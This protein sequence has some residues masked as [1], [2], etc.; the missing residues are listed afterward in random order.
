VQQRLNDF[1][2]V[3]IPNYELGLNLSYF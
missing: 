3:L 1:V 2:K